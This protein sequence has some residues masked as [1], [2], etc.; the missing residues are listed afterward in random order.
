[1]NKTFVYK[2]V[3]VILFYHMPL[4]GAGR[5]RGKGRRISGRGEGITS[6]ILPETR[7]DFKG[8]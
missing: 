4:Y 1:M 8:Y 7:F 6:L 5:E 2:F 3:D